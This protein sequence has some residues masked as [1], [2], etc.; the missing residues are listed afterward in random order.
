MSSSRI[1][2]IIKPK[3]M[4]NL[5]PGY[6]TLSPDQA[7]ERIMEAKGLPMTEEEELVR[8]HEIYKRIRRGQQMQR[9]H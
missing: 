9:D 7:V 6:H 2:K 5:Y 3:E 1:Y 4:R 8:Q